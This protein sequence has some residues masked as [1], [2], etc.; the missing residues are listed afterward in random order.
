MDWLASVRHGADVLASRVDRV[1]VG[2]ASTGAVLAL[3]LAQ[4]RPFHLAGVLALSPV[5]R[6]DGRT[7]RRRVRVALRLLLLR[8][9]GMGRHRVIQGRLRSADLP[10]IPCWSLVEMRKLAASVSRRMN[11]LRAP[12]LVIHARHD[13]VAPVSNAFEIVKG[14]RNTNVQLQLLTDRRHVVT[15]GRG[16][17]DVVSRVTAFVSNTCLNP[18]LPAAPSTTRR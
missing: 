13:D 7:V 16:C 17:G 10:G 14:A 1:V 5:F 12:C 6:H 15:M 11:T 9:L 8:T 2:G 4:E 18:S 3:A